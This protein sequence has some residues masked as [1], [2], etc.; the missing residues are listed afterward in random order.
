MVYNP[1][2]YSW[3]EK[4]M[5]YKVSASV[6]GSVFEQIELEQGHVTREAFL[7]K[8]RPKKSP[9]HC[10]FEWDDKKAAEKYRL[11]TATKIINSLRITYLDNDNEPQPVTAFIRTTALREKPKYVN[12]VEALKSEESRDI[13][14]E[15]LRRELE[16]FIERNKHIEEL[17]DILIKAGADLKAS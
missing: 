5:N 16:G 8:S 3:A 10:M 14:L 1:R 11:N 12:I 17:A 9:T 6:V 7:E 4:G 2:E 13:I 15:R